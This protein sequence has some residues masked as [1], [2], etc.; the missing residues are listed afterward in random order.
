MIVENTILELFNS[1]LSAN[2]IQRI[3][4]ISPNEAEVV[5]V[6]I[7]DKDKM[8]YPFFRKYSEI[9]NEINNGRERIIE[10]DPDLRLLSPDDEYLARYKSS[11]DANW[12]IIK[13]IV[14]QEPSIYIPAERGRLVNDT[15]EK[16]G[17]NKKV[18]YQLLKK[19]WF[20]GKS[21]NGLLRNYFECGAPGKTRINV[22]KTG[23]KPADKN[24]FIV[25][26]KDKKIFQTAISKFHVKEGK[27][28]TATH[29]HMCETYYNS[30]YYRKYNEMVPIVEQDKIP[31]LRQF[32]YWYHKE[33]SLV[34]KYSN[35]YGARKAVMDVRPLQG[36]ATERAR[37]VGFLYEI[38]STPADII[39]VAEDRKTILGTPTL[40]IVKD[41]FSRMVVGFHASLSPASWIEQMVALENASTSKVKFCRHYGIEIEKTDWPCSHLPKYLAGDRGELKG[42]KAENLVNLKVDVLNAPSYR[43]D[44]KPFVEQHF[45]ITNNKI[46]ELLY[47]AGAKPPKLIERGDKDPARDAALTIYEFIQFMIIQIITYNK[48]AL[49]KEYFVT[50]EM[51]GEK[52]ELT[53]LGVWN[54]GEGKKLLHEEP[55]NVIRYNLLPKEVVTVSRWGIEFSGMCYTS[56][57]GLEE[58]WFE[59]ERIDGDKNISISYDPRNVSSI[60]IRLK[61][62]NLEECFLTDKY[63]EYEGMHLEDVKAI[64]RYKREELKQRKREEKQHQAELHALTKNIVEKAKN[65]TKDATKDMSFY[66]RQKNKRET[67]KIES[68]S[69]GSKNA[70]TGNISNNDTVNEQTADI[71][72]FPTSKQ[73]ESNINENTGEIYERFASK[74][75]ERRKNREP[76]E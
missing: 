59:I 7:N 70:W 42:K 5:V 11:R 39:L 1:D 67:K 32:L 54:W 48:S 4:W 18:I 53:P 72:P 30:G 38:D 64:M 9:I 49:N 24:I 15:V 13:D 12:D 40:Y 56:K 21:I 28:L 17:K 43:G 65:A 22:K 51:F 76:L 58:G 8:K 23:P 34:R 20:Y 33:H 63:K 25:T 37:S 26:E 29:Q 73:N 66:E 35:K 68:R 46:R 44:L 10:I 57:L 52:V 74:N 16:T 71:V 45:N 31:T 36:D 19:Y 47:K 60:F 14:H 2:S 61:N 55:S 41:V 69:M 6:E 62:G 50:R 3:L 27:N 75:R